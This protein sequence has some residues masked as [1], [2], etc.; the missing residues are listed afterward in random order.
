DGQALVDLRREGV[1]PRPAHRDG[2]EELGHFLVDHPHVA[3]HDPAPVLVTVVA[4]AD[5]ALELVGDRA[6]F[7]LGKD[8]VAHHEEDGGAD[9]EIAGHQR[10]R[11]ASSRKSSVSAW[12]RSWNIS[13]S[14]ALTTAPAWRSC[15][16]A[17]RQ[18]AWVREVMASAATWTARSAPSRSSAVM[19]TQ[20]CASMPARMTRRVPRACR[21]ARASSAAQHENTT[22]ATGRTSAGSASRSS[23]KV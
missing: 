21:R 17:S 13:V 3:H 18:L 15:S 2:G 12:P 9:V 11:R 22:L 8:A 1:D 19:S 5:G 14:V 20:T 23:C 6:V 7:L 4:R 10:M 16:V